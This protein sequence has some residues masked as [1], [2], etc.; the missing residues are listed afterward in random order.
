[1]KAS[2][3]ASVLNQHGFRMSAEGVRKAWQRGAPRDSV[4]AF[5]AWLDK[6]SSRVTHNAVAAE[7]ARHGGLGEPPTI[8][9]PS[10]GLAL[11][12]ALFQRSGLPFW[13]AASPAVWKTLITPPAAGEATVAE[14]G[15]SEF[16]EA[17][18]NVV[19]AMAKL[20][21]IGPGLSARLDD[22][23][24]VS[25]PAPWLA[26]AKTPNGVAKLREMA[27]AAYEAFA[28]IPDNDPDDAPSS[29]QKAA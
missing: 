12:V 1:M 3:I 19:I 20:A 5:V 13:L 15:G 4:Q 7:R 24:V 2:E 16:L 18:I 28:A 9:S 8:T 10:V 25:D 17:A 14:L 27:C 21:E 11:L 22:A 26:A 29:Q 23:G 6:N